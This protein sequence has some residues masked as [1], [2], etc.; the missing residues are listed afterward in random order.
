M[1]AHKLRRILAALDGYV[2]GAVLCE[3]RPGGQLPLSVDELRDL[4]ATQLAVLDAR[5]VAEHGAAA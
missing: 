1:T 5:A 2:G 3:L 4:V